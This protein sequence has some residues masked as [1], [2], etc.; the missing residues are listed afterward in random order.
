[1]QIPEEWTFLLELSDEQLAE[2]ACV[3]R[4]GYALAILQERQH[5]DRVFLRRFGPNEG[6]YPPDAIEVR[7]R[8]KRRRKALARLNKLFTTEAIH[9]WC[10]EWLIG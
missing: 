8:I 10:Q 2:R 5:Q 9:R 6:S 1:M 3:Y 7:R 4:D